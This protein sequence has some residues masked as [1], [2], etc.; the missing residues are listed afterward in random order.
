MKKAQ[1][2]KYSSSVPG[3]SDPKLEFSTGSRRNPCTSAFLVAT[4]GSA[5][6]RKAVAG[7][8][9]QAAAS[10]AELVAL[11]VVPRYPI[12]FFE[13]WRKKCT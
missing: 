1:T 7:A 2:W 8:I 6:S 12:S 13:A 11:Y 4:D 5:L 3:S 10:G 9:G